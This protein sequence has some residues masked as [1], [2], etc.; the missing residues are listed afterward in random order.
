[1]LYA[2]D[3]VEQLADSDR[4]QPFDSKGPLRAVVSL[5]RACWT[6]VVAAVAMSA[7]AYVLVGIGAALRGRWYWLV[8]AVAVWFVIHTWIWTAV[9]LYALGSTLRVPVSFRDALRE[10]AG[11][12]VWRVLWTRALVE[13]G[14]LIGLICFVVPGIWFR[15][16]AILMLPVV[17]GEQVSGVAAIRRACAL[18]KGHV[19]VLLRQ[20]LWLVLVLALTGVAFASILEIGAVPGILKAL[21][22]AG[23]F[24]LNPLFAL[25]QVRFF[26]GVAAGIGY[27]EAPA[28]PPRVGVA[29]QVCAVVALVLLSALWAERALVQAFW[30]PSGNMMPTLLV[31]DHFFVDNTAYGVRLPLIGSRVWRRGAERGDVAV[32]V[33]PV[34][35]TTRLVSRVIAT[36][37]DTVEIRDKQLLLEGMPITDPYVYFD[38]PNVSA[39]QR[40]NLGPVTVPAGKLFVL[41][42]NRDRSYDSR[43]WGFADEQQLVGRVTWLYWSWDDETGRPRFERIGLWVE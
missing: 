4:A 36:A 3:G 43:F 34:D 11:R 40:D 12:P 35:N 16:R 24:A 14:T 10:T 42:D 25:W 1:M 2:L 37:G 29:G 7:T 15:L 6:P 19:A 17:V 41:G 5:Y 38:D 28:A 22:A 20:I 30:S 26:A 9:C 39:G 8:A 13:A 31:G 27:R 32:F 21:A 23:L 33:S 18:S